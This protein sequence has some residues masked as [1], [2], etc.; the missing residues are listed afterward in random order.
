MIVSTK[1]QLQILSS[2]CSLTSLSI[3]SIP[4]RA[5]V[6]ERYQRGGGP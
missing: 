4:H 1:I 2:V 3:Q 5:A 6:R